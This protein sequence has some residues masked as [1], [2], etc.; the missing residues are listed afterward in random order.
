MAPQIVQINFRLNV[1]TQ[2]FE[3][4]VEPMADPI[5]AVEGLRWKVWLLNA[6]AGEGGGIYLFDDAATARAYV[7]G[8]IVAN[9]KAAPIISEISIKQFGVVESLTAITRGPLLDTPRV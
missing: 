8:P 4:A 2:E 1:T 7:D 6:E 3:A 5:A 9:L